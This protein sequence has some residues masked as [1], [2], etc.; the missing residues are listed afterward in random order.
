MCALRRAVP[1][2][3]LPASFPLA[4]SPSARTLSQATVHARRRPRSLVN[5]TDRLYAIAEVLRATAPRARTARDLADRFEV[6]A[7]T[8]ERDISALP[9]SAVPLWAT[10]VPA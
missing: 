3:W 9:Q 4:R 5:R 8:I 6:S 2:W 1:R 7:R 10:P